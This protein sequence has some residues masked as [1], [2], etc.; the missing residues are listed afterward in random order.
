MFFVNSSIDGKN[1]AFM[2]FSVP[3]SDQQG[4]YLFDGQSLEKIVALNDLLDGK[5][6]NGLLNFGP[7]GLSGNRIAFEATFTDDSRGVYVAEI[8]P[9]PSTLILLG[10]GTFCLLGYAW[11]RCKQPIA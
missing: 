8:V 1:V 5:I 3:F 11:L 2:S 6:V 7:E 10:I 9:E 4:I